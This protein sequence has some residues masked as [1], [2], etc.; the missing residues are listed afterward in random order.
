MHQSSDHV[1]E[2]QHRRDD[3]LLGFVDQV[4]AKLKQL[5]NDRPLGGYLKRLS[6]EE[7]YAERNFAILSVIEDESGVI[8]VPTD[9]VV[10]ASLVD[11]L[12]EQAYN[13]IDNEHRSKPARRR[14][15]YNKN[16]P[17]LAKRREPSDCNANILR[18]LMLE[19]VLPALHPVQFNIIQLLYLDH[20]TVG[21]VASNLNLDRTTVRRLEKAA[22]ELLRRKL[23]A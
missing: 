17:F 5:I 14:R 12:A 19:E 11:G 4:D 9:I 20:K 18:K 15:L 10:Q 22:L 3:E 13:F 16:L 23:A 7:H 6:P 2:E 21:F 8:T 1:S